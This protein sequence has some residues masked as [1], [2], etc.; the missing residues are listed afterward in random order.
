[1]AILQKVI[2]QPPNLETAKK[3]FLM[4]VMANKM[5][6]VGEVT[7]HWQET[8]FDEKPD[9]IVFAKVRRKYKNGN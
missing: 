5:Q 6:V 8:L 3:S 1:M 2:Y 9:A 4:L 7:A